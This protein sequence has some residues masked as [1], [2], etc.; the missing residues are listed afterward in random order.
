M[1]N[2]KK[3]TQNKPLDEL[4]KIMEAINLIPYDAKME[5]ENQDIKREFPPLMEYLESP[6]SAYLLAFPF[7]QFRLVKLLKIRDFMKVLVEISEQYQLYLEGKP[8]LEDLIKIHFKEAGN[9]YTLPQFEVVFTSKN[10]LEERVSIF[11]NSGLGKRLFET[12]INFLSLKVDESHEMKIEWSGLMKTIQGCDIR[13]FRKCI[14]CQKFFW[15][16]RLNTKFCSKS[17]SNVYH[18][19][20]YLTDEDKRKAYNEKRRKTYESKK[21]LKQ[22]KERRKKNGTL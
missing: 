4:L 7:W 6:Q 17:C 13:R 11:D 8:N 20:I 15:A 5:F 9:N 2:T 14:V 21:E 1:R 16:Y 18:Q 22:G 10:S 12:G 3:Q 19:R